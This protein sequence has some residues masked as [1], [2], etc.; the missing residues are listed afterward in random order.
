LNNPLLFTD[1]SGEIPILA[2]LAYVAMQGI[3]SGDMAKDSE[4][5]FWGGFALGAG[6]AAISMG[7]GPL[8]GPIMSGTGFLPGAVNPMVPAAAVGT[9]TYGITSI[10]TGQPFNWQGLGM[11]IGIAGVLGGLQGGFDAYQYNHLIGP[12]P[13]NEPD[14]LN[15]WTGSEKAKVFWSPVGNNFGNENG[16][17][18]FRCLEEFSD[19]YGLDQYDHN[20]WLDRYGNKLGVKP[21]DLKGLVDGTGIF[22]S[23]FIEREANSIAKAFSN[24]QRVLMGFNTENGKA[25]AVMVNKVKIWTSSGRYKIWFAETSQIR[26]VPYSITNIL[27][28]DAAT[29]WT[30]FPR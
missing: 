7:V 13:M 15:F 10:A 27:D 16:E 6:T 22:S 4:M 14:Y 12:R 25:H 8:I 9:V 30:F 24:D 26:Q 28:I 23:D 17:C 18:V 3:I 19:S 11:N 29:F 21:G 2:V 20:Y 1:P 5:G